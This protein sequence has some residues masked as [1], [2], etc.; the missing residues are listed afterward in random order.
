MDAEGVSAFGD[1]H[2]VYGVGDVAQ[3]GEVE[4]VFS[5]GDGKLSVFSCVKCG[6]SVSGVGGDDDAGPSGHDDVAEFFE[7]EGG[8]VEFYGE[9]VGS[10]GVGGCGTGG[11]DEVG[12]VSLADGKIAEG[13]DG[14]AGGDV[15]GGGNCG[16]AGLEKAACG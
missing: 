15:D 4:E 1:L 8:S 7:D 12:E 6:E 14:F 13:L 3:H 9:D 16:E 11:V 2:G 5:G 10:G